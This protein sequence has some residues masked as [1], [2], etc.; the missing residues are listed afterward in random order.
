MFK[1]RKDKA[2]GQAEPGSSEATGGPPDSSLAVSS[3]VSR[4]TA[5]S[6][7]ASRSALSSLPPSPI[8]T[9]NHTRQRSADRRADP[10]GLNVVFEP[11][12]SPSLDIIFVHG[13]GGT[14]RQTWSK[15]RDPELF[16][17]QKWLPLEPDIQSAR[18]L[19]FGYNAHFWSSGPGSISRISDFAK[20]LLYGMRFS[21]GENSKNLGIGEVSILKQ[22]H[23]DVL[24]KKI[25]RP[26]IF[27]VHSMGGL[28]VKKVYPPLRWN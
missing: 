3:D 24:L 18:V 2:A 15:N 12:T 10:L 20:D 9:T 28:V 27:V 13:L 26:I 1:A 16:W 25:Q 19:T 21:Q 5:T 11:E 14:S 23:L 17:P 8:V 6:S 22:S 7:G 4:V